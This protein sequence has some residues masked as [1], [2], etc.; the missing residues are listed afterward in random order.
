MKRH[1][2]LKNK[3]RE[4]ISFKMLWFTSTLLNEFIKL[5]WFWGVNHI[6]TFRKKYLIVI[7]KKIV[8]KNNNTILH[9]KK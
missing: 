7:I 4:F 9:Q 8:D 6:L 2:N 5:R 1:P 3:V